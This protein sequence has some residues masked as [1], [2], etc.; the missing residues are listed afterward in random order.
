MSRRLLPLAWLL[1]TLGCYAPANKEEAHS[2]PTRY[3]SP[4][5]VFDACEAAK[6]KGDFR[7]RIGCFTPESQK[8]IAFHLAIWFGEKRMKALASNEVTSK[9]E[10]QLLAPVLDAMD[11]HGFT[12]KAYEQVSKEGEGDERKIQTALFAVV[13][14]PT[15]FLLDVWPLAS[16]FGPFNEKNWESKLLD[17]EIEGDRA[18]GTVQYRYEDVGNRA[19]TEGRNP[20]AFTKIDGGWRIGEERLKPEKDKAK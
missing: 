9:V 20:I 1:A 6:A 14:D 18:T 7:I 3:E 4:Q 2:R 19:K 10:L 17:V 12:A 8:A 13:K 15:T 16:A 5:A 11:K